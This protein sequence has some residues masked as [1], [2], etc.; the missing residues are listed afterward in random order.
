ML[1][2]HNEPVS[3][4][5]EGRKGLRIRL[6]CGLGLTDLT[7]Y[8]RGMLTGS[9]SNKW[10]TWEVGVGQSFT[11][12]NR[13]A[14][15]VGRILRW[16]IQYLHM[17]QKNECWTSSKHQKRFP[18]QSDLC[19]WMGSSVQVGG[20][21]KKPTRA[22]VYSQRDL[23]PRNVT[24]GTRLKPRYEKNIAEHLL[25]PD[26]CSHLKNILYIISFLSHRLT[27]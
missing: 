18:R 15:E 19:L 2:K 4:V 11:H 7:W 1:N 21:T 12:C 24:S 13:V 17:E 10:L 8:L 27:M 20:R 25:L 5:V 3:T 22:R 16:G 6:V 26:M 14:Q 9:H 23:G